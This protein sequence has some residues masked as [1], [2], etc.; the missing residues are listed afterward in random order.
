MINLFIQWLMTTNQVQLPYAMTYINKRLVIS[1]WVFQWKIIFNP[2][3]TNQVPEKIFSRKTKKLLHLSLSFNNVPLKN[4]MSQKH[5]GLILDVKLNFVEYI[6]IITQKISKTIS[7]LHKFP[8]ILS[9]S[10]FH[11]IHARQD[12]F[13]NLFFPSTIFECFIGKLES[14]VSPFFFKKK[15]L[16]FV[17]IVFLVFI[18]YVESSS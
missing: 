18:I 11:A 3:L 6:K 16:Y 9:R 8:P 5:F 2:D 1:N 14:Q 4:S 15:T 10:T 13:K 17:Q 7:L 12:Y